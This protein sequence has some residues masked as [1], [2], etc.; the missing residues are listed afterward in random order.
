MKSM[1]LASWRTILKDVS[2][3]SGSACSAFCRCA[4]CFWWYWGSCSSTWRWNSKD[5]ENGPKSPHPLIIQYMIERPAQ[6]YD[7]KWSSDPIDG[8]FQVMRRGTETLAVGPQRS[9]ATMPWRSRASRWARHWAFF[10]EP[11]PW[12]KPN[13]GWGMARKK[14]PRW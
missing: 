8:F 10:C 1:V 5:G 4:S 13:I 12:S 6:S 3:V 2:Q 11:R 7:P 14:S 9:L